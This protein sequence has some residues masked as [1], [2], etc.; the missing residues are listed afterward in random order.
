[1]IHPCSDLTTK[2]TQALG[3]SVFDGFGE[4]RLVKVYN[5]QRQDSEVGSLCVRRNDKV[6]FCFTVL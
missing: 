5:F 1:M 3:F 4:P 2:R 6:N